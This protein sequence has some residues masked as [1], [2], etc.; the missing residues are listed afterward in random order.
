VDGN[1]WEENLKQVAGNEG[2]NTVLLSTPK[3]KFLRIKLDES[4]EKEEI[5]WTMRQMKIFGLL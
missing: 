5:P 4:L 2:D 3:V 1:V